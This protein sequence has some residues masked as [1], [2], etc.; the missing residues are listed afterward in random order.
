MTD[1]TFFGFREVSLAI[2]AL[3]LSACASAGSARMTAQERSNSIEQLQRA[4]QTDLKDALDTELGPAAQGEYMMQAGKAGTAI[5]DLREQQNV[6]RAEISDALFVPPKHL[7]PA[8]RVELIKQL[9]QAKALDN[10]IYRNHLGGYDPILTEDCTVQAQRVDRVTN[11]LE[12]ERQVSWSEIQ[13][14]MWVPNENAW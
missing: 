8:E 11:E 1:R 14:A 5:S 3:C 13:E 6:S 9:E 12:T 7:S 2:A 4:R 10:Q